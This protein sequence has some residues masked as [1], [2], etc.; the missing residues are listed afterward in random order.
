MLHIM[1]QENTSHIIGIFIV[2][3]K[4]LTP[5]NCFLQWKVNLCMHHTD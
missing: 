2:T 3:K 1:F 4:E 5:T